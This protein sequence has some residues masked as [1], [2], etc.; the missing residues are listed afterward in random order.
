MYDPRGSE[1]TA[2]PTGQ[3]ADERRRYIRLIR[4]IQ[5]KGMTVGLRPIFFVVDKNGNP[6]VETLED[7]TSVFGGTGISSQSTQISGSNLL[8]HT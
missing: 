2:T 7:G 8:K 3:K 1:I 5:K 6:Y 4:Y